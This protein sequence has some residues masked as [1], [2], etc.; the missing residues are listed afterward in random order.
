MC[1]EA[2]A[3]TD[4]AHGLHRANPVGVANLGTDATRWCKTRHEQET[5]AVP[6]GISPDLTDKALKLSKVILGGVEARS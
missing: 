1:L 6:D 2:A 5:Q 3:R 4:M